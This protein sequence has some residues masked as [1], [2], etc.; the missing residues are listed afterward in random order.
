MI[1]NAHPK[2]DAPRNC[3][4]CPRL[5][6][7][8]RG[9]RKA[10]PVWFNAP[11]PTWVP[12]D[13][14]TGVHTLIIGLAPSLKGANRTGVPFTGD[15]AGDTLFETLKRAGLAHGD[16]TAEPNASM[17]LVGCAITN[18]VRCIPPENKP[19]GA[20]VNACTKRYLTRTVRRFPA[21]KRI[22][23]LGKIAH[24]ATVRTLGARVADH[25]F[26]HD[27]RS[28]V[29]GLELIASYHCSRYNMNTGRLTAQM[30]EAVFEVRG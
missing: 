12:P 19:V 13:G 24:D 16:Y 14:D 23:T 4:A 17:Q 3:R 22:I 11:V 1:L 2:A 20:E 28:R 6:A 15:S 18:A 26:G 27:V 9:H 25:P 10:Q 7:F 21:L 30:F 29:G 5:A 8:V